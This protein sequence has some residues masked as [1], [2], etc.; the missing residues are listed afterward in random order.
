MTMCRCE[1]CLEIPCI[2]R[3]QDC[4]A[5]SDVV[6]DDD[7][8]KVIIDVIKMSGIL[9]TDSWKVITGLSNID[10]NGK[11]HLTIMKEYHMLKHLSDHLTKE[12]KERTYDIL[13]SGVGTERQSTKLNNKLKMANA[14]DN[15]PGDSRTIHYT[16]PK[17]DKGDTVIKINN[18]K[19]KRFRN[20]LINI[21]GDSVIFE[22]SFDERIDRLH[23]DPV[24]FEWIDKAASDED[25]EKST[26]TTTVENIDSWDKL[27]DVFLYCK[28]EVTLNKLFQIK[29]RKGTYK[30]YN[31]ISYSNGT[32]I[33]QVINTETEEIV[34]FQNN[35][36]IRF[37]EGK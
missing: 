15:G 6:V 25:P 9:D 28:D 26:S 10:T 30:F 36:R 7:D 5:V 13:N 21:G 19:L 27:F 12:V 11:N 3:H 17:F 2:C 37:V 20:G 8:A 31:I 16:V 23:V 14:V 1:K 18:D 32:D 24:S 4:T 35:A 29:Y 34:P 33:V 22:Y